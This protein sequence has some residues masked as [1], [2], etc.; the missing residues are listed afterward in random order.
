MSENTVTN[1]NEPLFIETEAFWQQISPSL[2]IGNPNPEFDRPAVTFNEEDRKLLWELMDREG[3]LHLPPL[4]WAVP[5]QEMALT[6]A[7]IRAL[8]LPAICAFV[9]DEFWQIFWSLREFLSL[10]LGDDYK[11]QYAIWAWYIDPQA[12]ESGW[13]PHRDKGHNALDPDGKPRALTIW[14]PL[15]D[16]TPLNGCMYLVPKDRDPQ[17]GIDGPTEA[18]FTYADIRALP[19]AA[20]SLLCWTQSILH[21]GSHSVPRAVL[22]RISLSVEF[23][24]ADV[25]PMSGSVLEPSAIPSFQE[26]LKM[27]GVEL[28][29][30]Q[31]MQPLT[32]ELAAWATKLSIMDV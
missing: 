23:Q 10:I 30:Y 18:Q 31:H 3:Y 29:H 13:K 26:R 20:G 12:G 8:K 6:I 11:M 7:R 21:W 14:L 16:A 28:L 1:P 25:P 19:A 2:R 9:Y 27:I 32:P 15:T 4:N 5:I 17:Y 22:P 24:R